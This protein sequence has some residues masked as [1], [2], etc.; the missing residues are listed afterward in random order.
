MKITKNEMFLKLSVISLLVLC[1]PSCSVDRGVV[2]LQE[3][4]CEWVR[5]IELFRKEMESWE[6][7]HGNGFTEIRLGRFYP[8]YNSF[9]L[10]FLLS[11]GVYF[12]FRQGELDCKRP[13]SQSVFEL[14]TKQNNEFGEHVL[15]IQQ[16]LDLREKRELNKG[17]LEE[18]FL[19]FGRKEIAPYLKKPCFVNKEDDVV[20]L[21]VQDGFLIRRTVYK[22]DGFYGK[23]ELIVLTESVSRDGKYAIVSEDVKGEVFLF[24]ENGIWW[25][26]L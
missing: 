15:S 4:D 20:I 26:A 12:V 7:A 10:S 5:K 22:L 16:V 1:M 14:W 2:S 24:P 13:D 9:N 25:G 21:A 17:S 19:I 11:N 18:L 3:D 8:D 6:L 23:S